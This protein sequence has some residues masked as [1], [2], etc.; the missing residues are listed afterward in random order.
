MIERWRWVERA[1]RQRFFV[2][3]TFLGLSSAIVSYFDRCMYNDL[4]FVFAL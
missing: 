1:H 3:L 2:R 4:S